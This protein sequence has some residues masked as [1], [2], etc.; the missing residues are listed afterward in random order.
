MQI[1]KSTAVDPTQVA[2]YGYWGHFSKVGPR[3]DE[4]DV[5]RISV[6][7]ND[8]GSSGEQIGAHVEVNAKVS[9]SPLPPHIGRVF[10]RQSDDSYREV[11][12]QDKPSSVSLMIE[13]QEE[14]P[15]LHGKV[16]H[17]EIFC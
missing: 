10:L 1:V 17:A 2:L 14:F 7:V 4:G 15:N 5:C 6:F 9:G 3:P 11:H 13:S 12:G 8:L 16:V